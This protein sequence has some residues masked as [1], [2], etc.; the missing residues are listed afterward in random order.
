MIASL[1][2]STFYAGLALAT[3]LFFLAFLFGN[4][5]WSH[6]PRPPR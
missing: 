2:D 6:A 4:R 3:S 5:P 1:A